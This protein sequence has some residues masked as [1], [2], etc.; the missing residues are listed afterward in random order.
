MESTQGIVN[1]LTNPAMPNLVKMGI[2][3][4]ENVKSRMEQLDTVGVT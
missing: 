3:N 1:I 2:T 4:I